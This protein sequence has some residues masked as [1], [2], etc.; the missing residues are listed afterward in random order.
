MNKDK[1]VN[2]LKNDQQF[3]LENFGVSSIA[4][5]GSYAKGLENDASDLDFLVEF[6]KLSY[7]NLYNLR[8]YLENKF[9]SKIDLVRK[10]PHLSTK[11]LELIKNELIYV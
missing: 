11:F 6:K 8:L 7:E 3:L 2:E 9:G 4:L 5:F 10:G 1:I